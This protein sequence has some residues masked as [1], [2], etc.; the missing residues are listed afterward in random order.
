MIVGVP[1]EIKDNENRV[2][3]VPGGVA[4][5]V[6]HGHTVLVQKGAGL[7]SGF[8]D[9]AYVDKGAK[10]V[11]G[12]KEIFQRADMIVKVKEPLQAEYP[13]IRKGQILFTYFHFAA[14]EELTRAMLKTG[15]TCIAYETIL[16]AHGRLPLLTPMSEVAGRMAAQIGAYYLQKPEGGRGVLLGGVPGVPYSDVV[17]IGGG[18]VGTQAAWMAA[19]LGARV[20]ILDISLDRLRYLDDVMPK[21]VTTLH[22]NPDSILGACRRADLLIGAVLIEGAKAPVL[23][24]RSYLKEMKEGSVIVDVA[25]DQ[26]GCIETTKPTTHSNPTFVVDGVLHY[27]VA[28]MP[29]AVP[30]TSTYALTNATIPYAVRLADKGVSKAILEDHGFAQ[31]I[32]V[33]AGK[34]THPG[35]AQAFGLELAAL[36]SVLK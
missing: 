12:A 19:G 18:V 33:I 6:A 4:Q 14:S 30:R 24:P 1:T 23:V 26:G 10:I 5:L 3:M 17:I 31:G 22:S 20:T 36:E 2:G 11:D 27:C 16:D 35:V 13:L 32:N 25:V 8:Q 29:G 15:A 21:N 9:Q 28:N 34:V 7:G